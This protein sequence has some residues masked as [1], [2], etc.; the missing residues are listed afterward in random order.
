MLRIDFTF[1]KKKCS[2]CIIGAKQWHHDV[3]TTDTDQPLQTVWTNIRPQQNVRSNVN[4]NCLNLKNVFGK[5]YT[6]KVPLQMTK[7][8]LR[9]QR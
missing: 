2:T 3:E 8:M 1:A 9:A 6:E 4:P 5:N 7:S